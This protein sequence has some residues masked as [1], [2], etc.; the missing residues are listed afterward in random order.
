MTT[1]LDAELTLNL[2]VELPFKNKTTRE[3]AKNTRKGSEV[4]GRGD[5]ALEKNL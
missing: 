2:N 1:K 4:L 3:T 5:D